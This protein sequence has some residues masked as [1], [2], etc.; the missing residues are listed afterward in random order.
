MLVLKR[1]YLDGVPRGPHLF[2]EGIWVALFGVG[3]AWWLFP[4]EVSLI[5][6]FLAAILSDDSIERVL[7]WNRAAIIERGMW[8]LKANL[9]LTFKLLMVFLGCVVGFSSL[10]LALPLETV[11]QLFSH[12]LENMLDQPFAELRFGNV[13]ALLL[14]NTYVLLFF[15]AI[16]LPFRHGGVMLAIAWN[17]SVWGATFSV[18]ARRWTEQGGPELGWAWLRV[19]AACTPHMALEAAAYVLAGLAGVFLSKALVKYSIDSEAMVSILRSIGLM[20]L[21]GG[22]TVVLAALFESLAAPTLVAWVAG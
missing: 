2:V 4:N 22:G 20:L 6:V 16:A 1:F 12:Q 10:G 14:N 8:P 9:T 17:A 19:M 5:A 15:F 13:S 18:L 7:E 21:L 11:E 3:F